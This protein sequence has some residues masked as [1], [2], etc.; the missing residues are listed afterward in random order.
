MC[1]A[2]AYWVKEGEEELIMESVDLVEPEGDDSWRLVGIFGDR[3]TVRGRIGGMNLVDHKIL[4]E[5]QGD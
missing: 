5:A 4:F 2:N 3:K 1:E